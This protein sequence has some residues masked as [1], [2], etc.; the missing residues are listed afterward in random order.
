M[1]DILAGGKYMKSYQIFGNKK[2][3]YLW[4]LSV[5]QEEAIENC[6]QT[7]VQVYAS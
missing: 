5:I 4:T 6:Y 2:L 1:S 3:V 7:D